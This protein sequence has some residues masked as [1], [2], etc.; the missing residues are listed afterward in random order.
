M[1][2]IA[3]RK[4]YT[5]GKRNS[6]LFVYLLI[7]ILVLW[8]VLH[9]VLRSQPVA[10][11]VVIGHR[12]L[13][14]RGPENTI[15]GIQAAIDHGVTYVEI[16]VQR[17]ADGVL[18]LMHD[19]TLERTTS[20]TGR[21]ADRTWEYLQT[22]NAAGTAASPGQDVK[23]PSLE[24][25]LAFIEPSGAALVLEAKNP[26]LYPGIETQIVE[27]LRQY[28]MIERSIIISFNHEWLW[29]LAETNVQVYTGALNFW[30]RG[31]RYPEIVKMIDVNWVSVLVDPTLVY[32][33]HQKGYKLFVWTPENP[34]AIRF[35]LWAGVDGVT[36]NDVP[37]QDND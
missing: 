21:V 8:T 28:R 3:Q 15:A 20:G 12:G 32:R 14:N 37:F 6:A 25:A 23:I 10:D 16:D 29:K 5:K 33:V 7:A 17:T 34:L 31:E 22:L 36:V 27:Q 4:I 19:E 24:D 26:E 30:Y 11:P 9:L 35:L 2:T 1:E 18:V 13:A